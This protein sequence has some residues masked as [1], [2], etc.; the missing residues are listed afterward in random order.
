MF[1]IPPLYKKTLL[2]SL[3]GLAA[4]SLSCHAFAVPATITG[5]GTI[6]L[7]DSFVTSEE[8]GSKVADF[9][10]SAGV[11]NKTGGPNTVISGGDQSWVLKTA[12]SGSGQWAIF[13]NDS[14]SDVV[15]ADFS[16]LRILSESSKILFGVNSGKKGTFRFGEQNKPIS[17]LVLSSLGATINGNVSDIWAQDL[18]IIGGDQ[19]VN[20]GGGEL[21]IHKIGDGSG[22]STT[23]QG[24]RT[25]ILTNGKVTIESGD[26]T[27]VGIVQANANGNISFDV[28]NYTA[29][30]NED[31]EETGIALIRANTN[32]TVT[33]RAN[34]VTINPDDQDGF[35]G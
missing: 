18:L 30:A 24:T 27:T 35:G 8:S 2:A 20:N 32:A 16:E 15:F 34:D 23:I 11:L 22:Q 33:I 25:A 31:D 1:E 29:K 7:D 14:N 13:R 21:T 6:A 19:A 3:V 26:L 28:N 9:G 5:T 17:S 12:Y 4:A 10:E